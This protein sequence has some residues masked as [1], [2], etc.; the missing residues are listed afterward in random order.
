MMVRMKDISIANCGTGA[1]LGALPSE[2]DQ[3][4][5]IERGKLHAAELSL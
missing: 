1:L 3:S 4:F 5:S 2:L